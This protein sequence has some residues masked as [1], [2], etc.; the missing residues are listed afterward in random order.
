LSSPGQSGHYQWRANAPDTPEPV[1]LSTIVPDWA[2]LASETQPDEA[3]ARVARIEQIFHRH[4]DAVWR[5]ARDLGVR[6]DLEDVVQ[7]VM[8]VCVRRLSDIDPERERAFLLATTARVVANWRRGR[9]RRPAEPMESMDGLGARA[10][11]P[12][13]T[14]EGPAE[15]LEHKRDLELVQMALEQMSEPQRVAFTLF[16]IEGL[17]AREIAAELGLSELVVFARVQRARAVF[18][19][20][21]ERARALGQ[22]RGPA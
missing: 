11:D 20:H 15:A 18:H 7:E 1:I 13:V 19:R 3:D 5:T 9:R 10:L 17:T 21:L 2:S 14:R 6:S 12:Y 4:L 16:D 22:R 8:V